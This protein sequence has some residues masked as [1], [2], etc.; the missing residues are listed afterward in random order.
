ME[1]IPVNAGKRVFAGVAD[2]VFLMDVTGSMSPCIDVLKR[3]IIG[4]IDRMTSKIDD[5]PPVT[6]WRARVVGY[7]DYENDHGTENEWFV[8]NPFTRDANELKAQIQNMYADGGGPEPESLLDAMMKVLHCRVA[9]NELALGPTDWRPMD[10]AAHCL[11]IFT[12]APYYDT[13]SY[14][15]F[16]G[17]GINEILKMSRD[18]RITGFVFAPDLEQYEKGVGRL[19]KYTMIPC[20]NGA[21]GLGKVMQDN[22]QLDKLLDTLRRGIS[23]SASAFMKR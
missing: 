15:E 6:D 1:S 16:H 13:I 21:D 18:R 10:K 9:D 7:R 4:F 3:S 12:D 22:T 14:P 5:V 17:Q 19:P 20:G 11:V 2:I 23:M 8:D